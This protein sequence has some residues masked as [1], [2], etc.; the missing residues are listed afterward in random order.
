[1]LLDAPFFRDTE[2][3]FLAV[4]GAVPRPLFHDS[5]YSYLNGNAERR[6]HGGPIEIAV[7]R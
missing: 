2:G 3:A 7:S 4:R 5:D 6:S 1:M